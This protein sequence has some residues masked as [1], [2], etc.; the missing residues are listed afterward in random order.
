MADARP[1]PFAPG[2]RP[3]LLCV[4]HQIDVLYAR[5]LVQAVRDGI[6]YEDYAG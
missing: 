4:G 3:R 6:D 2:D 5:F 1:L